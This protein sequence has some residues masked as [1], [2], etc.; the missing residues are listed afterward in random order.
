MTIASIDALRAASAWVD[1]DGNDD[2]DYVE[3]LFGMGVDGYYLVPAERWND[4]ADA[5]KHAITWDSG[6]R[7]AAGKHFIIWR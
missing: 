3:A 1:V 2:N 6:V 4:V 5:V 7:D